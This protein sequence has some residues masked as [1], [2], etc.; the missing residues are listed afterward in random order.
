MFLDLYEINIEEQ[1]LM[2]ENNGNATDLEKLFSKI[3][4][5]YNRAKKGDFSGRE[6]LVTCLGSPNLEIRFEVIEMIGNIG[7]SW[8]I[9]PLGK[10]IKDLNHQIR[11]ES[12]FALM[13]TCRL[14]AVSIL[15]ET[16]NDK[17]EEIKEDGR[18]AL[19]SLLGKIVLPLL[20]KYGDTMIGEYLG[21]KDWWK[22][23][24][25]LFNSDYVY[26]EGKPVILGD[27]IH[28]LEWISESVF[29]EIEYRLSFWTGVSFDA[30][31]GKKIYLWN[32]WWAENQ[33][34]FQEGKRYFWGNPVD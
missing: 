23:N 6:V 24:H 2:K 4:V 12:I 14:E 25:S 16:L 17:N 1:R 29:S 9:A 19:V 32:K 10:L 28:S 34:K 3:D 18:V 5:A 22:T 21:M 20:A 13:R 26:F 8:G 27:W 33:N 31:V 7:A 30:N 11:S 15:I